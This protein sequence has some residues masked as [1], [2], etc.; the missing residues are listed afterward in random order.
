M[1]KVCENKLLIIYILRE[2]KVNPKFV[3][4]I[5]CFKYYQALKLIKSKMNLTEKLRNNVSNFTCTVEM[6]NLL[7]FYED[8]FNTVKPVNNDYSSSG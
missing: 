3:V 7:P 6:Q 2:Q 1:V 5:D 4:K 8:F